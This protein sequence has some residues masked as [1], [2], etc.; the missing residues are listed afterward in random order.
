MNQEQA[1]QYLHSLLKAM[2]G[3]KASDLFISNDFPP[4]MKIDGKMT[5]ATAQRLTPCT[6]RRSPTPS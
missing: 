2:L 1:T 6:P 4:S 3:K 5:P